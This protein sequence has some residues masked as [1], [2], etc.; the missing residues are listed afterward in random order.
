[1]SANGAGKSGNYAVGETCRTFNVM[2]QHFSDLR[3]CLL[4]VRLNCWR[5]ASLLKC[6]R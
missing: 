5:M 6:K 3:E 1:V 4:C 2:I